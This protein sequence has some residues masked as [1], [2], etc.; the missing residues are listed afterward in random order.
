[1]KKT[2]SVRAFVIAN[3]DRLNS[4]PILIQ[5][6]WGNGYLVFNKFHPLY[7]KSYDDINQSEHMNPHGGWTYAEIAGAHMLKRKTKLTPINDEELEIHNNDWIIGFDTGH[8]SDSMD[9]WHRE[10]V[11]DHT[12]ELKK[13]YSKIENFI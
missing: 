8:F 10:A 7:K 1:M 6:G 3:T 9:N 13:Y 11:I 2:Y 5:K 4:Y 12:E